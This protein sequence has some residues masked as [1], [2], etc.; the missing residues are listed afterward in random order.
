MLPWTKTQDLIFRLK[1]K[2]KH[3]LRMVKHCLWVERLLVSHDSSSNVSSICSVLLVP[4]EVLLHWYKTDINMDKRLCVY[5]TSHLT[6]TTLKPAGWV[7]VSQWECCR[8]ESPFPTSTCWSVFEQDTECQI[9][10]SGCI[11]CLAWQLPALVCECEQQCVACRGLV[12]WWRRAWVGDWDFIRAW[13]YFKI[14]DNA[15]IFF[16]ISQ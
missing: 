10:P 2:W 5:L 3:K 4:M 9:A 6:N 12:T 8:F 7:F 13:I 1:Y 16:A 15:G 14:E 11:E